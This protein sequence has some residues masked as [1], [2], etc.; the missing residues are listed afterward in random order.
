MD[1]IFYHNAVDGFGFSV[2]VF[3]LDCRLVSDFRR[4]F[5]EDSWKGWRLEKKGRKAGGR[6]FRSV[7]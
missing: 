2:H 4:S 3:H 7:K 6:T 1:L 5:L